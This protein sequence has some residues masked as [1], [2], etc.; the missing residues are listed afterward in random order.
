MLYHVEKSSNNWGGK[1]GSERV[2]FDGAK[3]S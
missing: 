2:V 3:L 1:G